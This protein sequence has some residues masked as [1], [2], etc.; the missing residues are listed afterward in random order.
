MQVQ[1]ETRDPRSAEYRDLAEHRVRFVMRRLAWMVSRAQ[2]QLSDVNGP[3]GGVDKRC[4]VMLK[5]NGR[6]VVVISSTASD[7]RAA[8]DTAL[9]RASRLLLRALRRNRDPSRMRENKLR[10]N[11]QLAAVIN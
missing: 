11:R 8:L 10:V 9:S 1:I 3:R 6:S 7:W 2:V 4:Q 5:T